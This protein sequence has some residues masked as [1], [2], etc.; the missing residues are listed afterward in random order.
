[1][2]IGRDASHVEQQKYNVAV[3][4]WYRLLIHVEVLKHKIPEAELSAEWFD[5]L[6]ESFPNSVQRFEQL[7]G[8]EHSNTEG[9]KGQAEDPETSTGGVQGRLA[10]LWSRFGPA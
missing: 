8:V 2:T 10:N 7:I 6:A 9:M 3:A 4:T 5:I 1:M